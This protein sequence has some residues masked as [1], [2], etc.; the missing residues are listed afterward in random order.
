MSKIILPA[1]NFEPRWYQ[2]GLWKYLEAGG[3]RAVVV[4]PRRHGKDLIMMN[5]SA[6]MSQQR[7]GLY[8]MVYPFLNQGRRIAWTGM[9]KEGQKFLDAFPK[10]LRQTQSNAEMR[11][12]LKN[13]SVF[14]VMGADQP[15]KFVGA[16]PVGVVF[17]EWALMDPYVW[18]L[19]LPILIEN[20]GWAVF[21]FTPRGENHGYDKL[22]EAQE[23]K[24]WFWS[25]LT[26][27][28]CKVLDKK[29]L[30]KARKQFKDEAL[31]QQEMFTN[32]SV[33]LQGAYYETQMK[34][35]RK[36]KQFTKVLWEPKLPVHTAWDLGIDD[37]TSIW[38]YQTF[39]N[40][41]RLIDFYTN[42]GEGLLHYVKLLRSKEYLYG[43]HYFPHDVEVRELTSGKTR[44]EALREMGVKAIPVKKISIE[45]GIEAVRNLLPR[46]WFDA[47]NCKHG[48]NA[49]QSY[50]KEKD[51]LKKTYKNKPLHDWSSHPAD[52]F[53]TLAVSHRDERREYDDRQRTANVKYDIFAPTRKQKPDKKIHSLPGMQPFVGS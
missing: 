21:I 14:Q 23:D 28:D 31:F 22:L 27:A 53:R 40:E 29:D 15:D 30:E 26:A 41:V 8:W 13:G 19:T 43:K 45:D 11:I 42:S 33:P 6:W 12:E 16:N 37:E 10:E 9:T 3:E 35:L 20:G 34:T 52:A 17:S 38:F 47:V 2:L 49:L 44:R 48:I 25:K 24:E 18:D 50:R 5:L 7:V 36:R 51:D 39:R 46:C 32:F 1:N 4:W